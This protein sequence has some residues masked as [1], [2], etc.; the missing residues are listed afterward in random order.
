MY[1]WV[2]LF[3]LYQTLPLILGSLLF[4]NSLEE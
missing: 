1:A 4:S 2:C 3:I